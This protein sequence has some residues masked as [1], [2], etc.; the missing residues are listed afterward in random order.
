M[1]WL[2]IRIGRP[3]MLIWIRQNDGDPIGSTTLVTHSVIPTQHPNVHQPFSR[4]SLRLGI[5]LI[6][7]VPLI[8]CLYF[9]YPPP[10]PIKDADSKLLHRFQLPASLCQIMI[11]VFSVWRQDFALLSPPA[12]ERKGVFSLAIP[13]SPPTKDARNMFALRL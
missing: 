13:I 8:D 12:K 5:P 7:G 1:K 6:K 3:W 10:P 4:Y 11:L 2:R 9:T